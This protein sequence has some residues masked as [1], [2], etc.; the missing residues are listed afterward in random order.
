MAVITAHG[1]HIVAI[2][3]A[4]H[5]AGFGIERFAQL[6]KIAHFQICAQAQHPLGGLLLALQHADE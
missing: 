5:D 2:G 6:V 3:H 4:V 1:D